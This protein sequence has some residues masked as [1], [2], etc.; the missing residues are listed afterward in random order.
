MKNLW[1]VRIKIPLRMILGSSLL[2]VYVLLSIAK[3]TEIITQFDPN[4]IG[5]DGVT[6]FERPFQSLKKVLPSCR[7]VGYL[8][9]NTQNETQR[10]A[11]FVLTQ[12]ALAPIIVTDNPNC[13][14]IIFIC[15]K[16]I[17][18]FR[19]LPNRNYQ[20][21]FHASDIVLLIHEDVK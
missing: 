17:I 13:Q 11:Q 7:I 9:N 19:M 2:M 15:D 4:A 16:G 21:L 3:Y 8:S 12:Y 20:E 18:D 1:S 5:R 10:S 14:F 6:L